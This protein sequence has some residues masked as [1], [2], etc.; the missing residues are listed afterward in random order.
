MM[1]L[2]IQLLCDEDR[3]QVQEKLLGKMGYHWG[4]DNE[5]KWIKEKIRFIY[6]YP[7]E[8]KLTYGNDG[9]VFRNNKNEQV[10]AMHFLYSK[11]IEEN[12]IYEIY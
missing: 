1:N 9:K 3:I 7:E 8:K 11:F 4:T 6:I 5:N 2:K 10:S 12:L